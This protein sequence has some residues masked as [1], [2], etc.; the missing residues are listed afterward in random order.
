MNWSTLSTKTPMKRTAMAKP[1]M[2]KC[3]VCRIEFAKRGMGHI[4][5]GMTCA[6]TWAQR[7]VEK[8]ERIAAKAERQAT[9]EQL[10]QL[11]PLHYW[12]KR[13]EKACNAY[14]RAR[15]AGDPCISCGT[16]DAPEWHAGHC[17]T[18]AARPDIRYHEDN[19]HLQCPKCNTYQGGM[20]GEYK[21]RV[22]SKIGQPRFDALEYVNP[23]FKK[24]REYYQSVEAHFKNLLRELKKAG[25]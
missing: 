6:Q 24:T 11:K 18:V 21:K 2:G 4:L 17:Y 7:E 14:I 8:K 20:V 5:C 10:M 15:D 23:A 1:K 3:R 12:A 13:A 19:I 16:Y 25:D 9:K 22:V